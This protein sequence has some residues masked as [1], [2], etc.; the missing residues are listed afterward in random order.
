MHYMIV[1][2]EARRQ[3][4]GRLLMEAALAAVIDSGA[5]ACGARVAAGNVANRALQ[6]SF[7][8]VRA[9]HGDAPESPPADGVEGPERFE[10]Y[11]WRIDAHRER[12]RA[13]AP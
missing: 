4:L 11:R 6:E 2:P 10:E 8:F 13:A 3:G 1:H 5:R 12:E 7:G 9:V